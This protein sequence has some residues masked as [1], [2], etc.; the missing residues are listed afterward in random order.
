[1]I[2]LPQSFE[3]RA[4]AASARRYAIHVGSRDVAHWCGRPRRHAAE[5]LG[6][7]K[8]RRVPKRSAPLH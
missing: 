4:V 8:P 2:I 3:R 7:T 6:R 5:L 1:M